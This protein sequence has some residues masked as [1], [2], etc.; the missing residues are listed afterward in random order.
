MAACNNVQTAP[1]PSDLQ[2]TLACRYALLMNN[3]A[4]NVTGNDAFNDAASLATS[5]YTTV[6]MREER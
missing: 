4:D 3:V 5:C 6:A 2:Y 1:R